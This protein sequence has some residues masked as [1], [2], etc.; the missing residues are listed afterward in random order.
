MRV[1][2]PG[3]LY[4]LWHSKLLGERS[5]GNPDN[6]P[7]IITAASSIQAEPSPTV[8]STLTVMT[9]WA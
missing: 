4:L 5:T 6:Y 2:H 7:A 8:L 1:P 3:Q 9:V